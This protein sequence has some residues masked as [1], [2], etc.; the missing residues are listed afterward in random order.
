LPLSLIQ[1]QIS[2]P[3][4]KLDTCNSTL[5]SVVWK[6]VSIPWTLVYGHNVSVGYIT[7]GVTDLSLSKGEVGFEDLVI[8][9]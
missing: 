7:T 3:G 9:I 2:F 1:I 6:W 5:S 8:V 4:R